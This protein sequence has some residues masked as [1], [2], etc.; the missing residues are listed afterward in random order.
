MEKEQRG[1]KT[2]VLKKTIKHD[3]FRNC[4]LDQSVFHREMTTLRSHRHVI[5]GETVN[6][7]ALSPLDTKRYI[8]EDGCSTLAFGHHEIPR[9]L[10]EEGFDSSISFMSYAPDMMKQ[11]VQ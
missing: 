6:K 9:Y 11:F 7:I 1:V 4:L 2:A 5:F 3:D 10:A 8:T